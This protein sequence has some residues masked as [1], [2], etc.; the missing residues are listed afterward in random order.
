LKYIFFYLRIYIFLR[1]MIF[2][3][4]LCGADA[5]LKWKT[6]F[7]VF[8]P[9]P[10]WHKIFIQNCGFGARLECLSSAL[11]CGICPAFWPKN[12]GQLA[13]LSQIELKLCIICEQFMG[14]PHKSLRTIKKLSLRLRIAFTSFKESITILIQSFIK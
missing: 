2:L 3:S 9:L 10:N 6:V 8:K 12:C 5:E 13:Y 7:T 11:F 14:S 4:C 1:K